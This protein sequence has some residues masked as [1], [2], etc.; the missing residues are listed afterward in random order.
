MVNYPYTENIPFSTNN[1]SVDQPFMQINTNSIKNLIGE[2][3]VTFGDNNGGFH[4]Q[5]RIPNQIVMPT[6]TIS[7]ST[8]IY[9]KSF[10]GNSNIFSSNGTSANE[11]QLTRQTSNSTQFGLFGSETNYAAPATTLG[12]WTFLPGNGGNVGAGVAALGA[13]MFQYGSGKLNGT[14][15]A[16]T[17]PITFPT[18]LYSLVISSKTL[19]SGLSGGPFVSAESTTGFSVVAPAG[20][21]G[22]TV[23]WMAI[24]L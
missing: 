4:N 2:D 23:Y 19:P 12:G 9:T 6:G 22:I 8:T 10:Q 16:F 11:Y 24:G 3:H 20:T 14:S 13:L 15:T 1:P 18:S 17:F 21:S 5:M 7:G